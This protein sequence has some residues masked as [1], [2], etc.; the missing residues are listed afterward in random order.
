MRT[1]PRWVRRPTS[2]LLTNTCTSSSPVETISVPVLTP[3]LRNAVSMGAGPKLSFMLTWSL[4]SPSVNSSTPAWKVFRSTPAGP[5]S[6]SA[7]PFTASFS[8]P[9]LVTT[10]ASVPRLATRT[11]FRLRT[12]TGPVM[13][14]G[15][16]SAISKENDA[17]PLLPVIF[18]VCGPGGTRSTMN[19][20][21][22]RSAGG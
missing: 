22:C 1:C 9:L 19:W 13:E 17:S 10:W 8:G 2:L 16:A 7:W 20:P 5:T 15:L 11:T 6:P 14:G 18:T 12:M 3:D 21:S 4:P